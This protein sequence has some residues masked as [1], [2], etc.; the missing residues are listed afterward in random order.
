[1][2]S[3]R[4][5]VS[6]HPD[7]DYDTVLGTIRAHD[8]DVARDVILNDLYPELYLIRFEEEDEGVDDE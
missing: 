3:Y 8:E 1:M 6:A 7:N 5:E 4:F 2:K